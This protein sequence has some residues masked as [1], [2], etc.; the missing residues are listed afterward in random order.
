MAEALAAQGVTA[1]GAALVQQLV[2]AQL[3]AGGGDDDYS[4][5]ASVIF[6]LAGL[7]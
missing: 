3:A 5:I 1:P 6:R 7:N 2:H 4:G